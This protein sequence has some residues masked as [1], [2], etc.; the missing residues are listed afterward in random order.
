MRRSCKLDKFSSTKTAMFLLF[1]AEINGAKYRS[2]L[3]PTRFVQGDPPA[4]RN[5]H[6]LTASMSA[7]FVFGGYGG[8]VG[9]IKQ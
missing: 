2:W 4:P 1:C 9:E 6:S 7:L 8:G 5:H 3:G